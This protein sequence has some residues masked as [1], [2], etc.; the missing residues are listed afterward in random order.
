MREQARIFLTVIR[1]AIAHHVEHSPEFVQMLANIL[2]ITDQE[3]VEIGAILKAD[4]REDYATH[5][6]FAEINDVLE[7]L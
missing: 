3:R 5:P 2:Q 4:M 7:T 1:E 6:C